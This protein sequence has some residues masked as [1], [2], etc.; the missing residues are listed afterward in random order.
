M[1]TELHVQLISG[2]LPYIVPAQPLYMF[3]LLVARLRTPVLPQ[4]T[5]THVDKLIHASHCAD[6]CMQ[7]PA[8]VTLSIQAPH[9]FCL[10]VG[11]AANR[12]TCATCKVP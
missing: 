7:H 8:R 4:Y 5:A 12:N 10:T 9:V 1:V 6:A 2:A 3:T 11:V